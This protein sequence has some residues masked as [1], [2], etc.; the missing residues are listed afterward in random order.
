MRT[1]L[2]RRLLFSSGL[3]VALWL[4]VVV[5]RWGFSRI[6]SGAAQ[7][8]NLVPQVVPRG[9]LWGESGGWLVVA[10]ALG[11]VAVALVHAVVTL[12]LIHI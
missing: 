9:L 8:A 7:L 11:A 3:A 4:L 1:P 12:S 5:V 2:S 6:P 10:I